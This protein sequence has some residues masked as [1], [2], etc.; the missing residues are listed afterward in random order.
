VALQLRSAIP[1]L[2]VILTSGYP[3]WRDQE[4]TDLETLGSYLVTILSKPFQGQ[5]LS[6]AVYEL[7]GAPQFEKARTV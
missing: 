1:D 6:N 4:A 2:P 5:A 3:D 7:I